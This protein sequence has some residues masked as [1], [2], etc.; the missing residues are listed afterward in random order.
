[1]LK[2]TG[3]SAEASWLAGVLEQLWVPGVRVA[4]PVRSSDGRWVI[5]GWTAH[6]FVA[7]R[8]APRFLEAL[9]VGEKLHRALADV[10]RPRFLDDRNSLYAWADRISWGDIPAAA[11]R[12]GDGAGAVTF[13]R[14]AAGRRPVQL[15]HQLVHGDLA[16][17]VLF[18][19]S[20][21]PAVIDMTPYWRPPMWA[22]AVVVVDAIAWGG[23]DLE[24]ARARQGDDWRQVL[25]RA[26]MFRLATALGR[27]PSASALTGGVLSAAE[28]LQPLLDDELPGL[29]DHAPDAHS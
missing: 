6:R 26:L 28:Q 5:A 29:G 4:R 13:A 21:P 24:I 1:V 9:E 10:A 2:H 7:G 20:A 15:P 17:N 22:S 27:L 14:L 23:A 3:D 16:G 19:G 18:A 12:L 25:R 8:P 11:P